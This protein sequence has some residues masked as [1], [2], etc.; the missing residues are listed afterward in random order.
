MGLLATRVLAPRSGVAPKP[1]PGPPKRFA[2]LVGLVFSVAA[3][4]LYYGVDS[5]AAANAVLGVLAFFAAL[6]ALVG[7]CAG[8]F[9]FVQLMRLGLIPQSVCEDCVIGVATAG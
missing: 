1:V 2:Q 4:S 3:L 8:C 5:A 9:V 7:F 6:E